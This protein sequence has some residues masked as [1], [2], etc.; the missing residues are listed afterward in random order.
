M[1]SSI[2]DIGIL[3]AVINL[4]MFSPIDNENRK[5]DLSEKKEYKLRIIVIVLISVIIYFA[6]ILINKEE[7][8]VCISVGIMLSACLQIPCI[9]QKCNR[10]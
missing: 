1:Y 10:K 6:L 4:I 3:W 8:A 2:F 7:Y 5:L 9:L